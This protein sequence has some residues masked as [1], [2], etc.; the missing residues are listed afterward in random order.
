MREVQ[1]QILGEP[2]LSHKLVPVRVEKQ[3]AI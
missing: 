1:E 3:E 2:G